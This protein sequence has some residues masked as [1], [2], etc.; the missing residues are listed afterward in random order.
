MLPWRGAT[1]LGAAAGS[2]GADRMCSIWGVAQVFL[3]SPKRGPV[4]SVREGPRE[5]VLG[6]YAVTPAWSGVVT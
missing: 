1:L 2:V 5:P 6:G 3:S 4:P